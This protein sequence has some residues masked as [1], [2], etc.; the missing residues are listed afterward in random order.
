M[1]D[2]NKFVHAFEIGTQNYCAQVIVK[3]VTFDIVNLEPWASLQGI[4]LLAVGLL[5]FDCRSCEPLLF[6]SYTEATLYT[7]ICKAK[8]VY[9]KPSER[10]SQV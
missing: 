3:K 6:S 4:H 2:D 1:V 8:L 10:V 5:K 7:E 9:S